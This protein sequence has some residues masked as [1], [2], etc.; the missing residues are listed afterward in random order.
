MAHP[1]RK[2]IVNQIALIVNSR[3]GKADSSGM[4]DGPSIWGPDIKAS[5]GSLAPLFKNFYE[6]LAHLWRVPI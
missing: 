3:R 6:K 2:A 1:N 4:I 5:D